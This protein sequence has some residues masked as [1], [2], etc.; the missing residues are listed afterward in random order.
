MSKTEHAS[1]KEPDKN[2]HIEVPLSF[3]KRLRMLCVLKNC[4]LKSYALEALAE[5]VSRDEAETRG[6]K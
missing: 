1:P 3:H 6:D 5:K 4:T 2:L